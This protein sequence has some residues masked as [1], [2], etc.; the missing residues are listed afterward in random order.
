MLESRAKTGQMDQQ[1]NTEGQVQ[2]KSL[3]GSTSAFGPRQNLAFPV[4]PPPFEVRIIA[5]SFQILSKKGSVTVWPNLT[6]E[7]SQFFL[8]YTAQGF[9][10]GRHRDLLEDNPLDE[11][12]IL[13]DRREQ[14]YI[15]GV[16]RNGLLQGKAELVVGGSRFEAEFQDNKLTR[17]VPLPALAE[18]HDD[19]KSVPGESYASL[20]SYFRGVTHPQLKHF[21]KEAFSPLF[22]GEHEPGSDTRHGIGSV[23]KADGSRF[24]GTWVRGT[25]EGF[26]VSVNRKGDIHIGWYKNGKPHSIGSTTLAKDRFVGLFSGGQFDG[27]GFYFCD[28]SQSWLH[29][30]FERGDTKTTLAQSPGTGAEQFYA[31]DAQLLLRLFVSAGQELQ[32]LGENQLPPLAA[33][34]AHEP[35]EPDLLAASWSL[36]FW[37][38]LNTS[39]DEAAGQ[40]PKP[41]RPPPTKAGRAAFRALR[42]AAAALSVLPSFDSKLIDYHAT[43]PINLHKISCETIEHFDEYTGKL[44]FFKPPSGEI[45]PLEK[46]VEFF[47]TEL[48]VSRP[49][50]ALRSEESEFSYQLETCHPDTEPTQENSPLSHEPS[51]PAIDLQAVAAAIR[52]DRFAPYNFVVLQPSSKPSESSKLKSR[53]SSTNSPTETKA[54]SS[55]YRPRLYSDVTANSVLEAERF[56]PEQ[57]GIYGQKNS[58]LFAD[59]D[60]GIGLP[61]EVAN[62]D[63]N[64][65]RYNS[66]FYYDKCPELFVPLYSRQ[67]DSYNIRVVDRVPR[68]PL[69]VSASTKPYKF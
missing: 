9:Y 20:F 45:E 61:E 51:C 38:A 22:V 14:V 34:A 1:Q 13:W 30:E 3:P 56:E 35:I 19:K 36:E 43:E 58:G 21:K 12:G 44:F 6:C 46:I 67:N 2:E 55:E 15:E 59:P 7:F 24:H 23:F 4:L 50:A 57:T 47:K 60:P 32:V 11:R 53:N 65:S 31:F 37:R 62:F 69:G 5:D 49:A 48:Q 29:C 26:G 27:V 17:S 10:F 39:L 16:W 33:I 42:V 64:D 8:S 25:I 63:S 18:E 28:D 40:S 41:K 66:D 52:S 68:L 54:S